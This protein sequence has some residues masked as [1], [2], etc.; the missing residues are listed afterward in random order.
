MQVPAGW[1]VEQGH[2][3]AT[4]IE[5]EIEKLLVQCSATAHVEPCSNVTCRW[6]HPAEAAP[7]IKETIK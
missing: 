2:R 7:A 1:S 4:S 3:V 5:M 6:C